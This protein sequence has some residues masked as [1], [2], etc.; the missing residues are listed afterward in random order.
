MAIPLLNTIPEILKHIQKHEETLQYNLRL[1]RAYEG[2]IRKEIEDSMREEIMSPAALRRALKRVPSINILK[3][4][5]DKL[6]K[7]YAEPVVRLTKNARDQ[8]LLDYYSKMANLDAVFMT[9]N[10]M[11]NL[12][13]M[14]AIEPFVEDGLPQFRVLAG[15]QFLPFSNDPVNPMKMNVFIK[16][17]GK[18]SK[19]KD[20]VRQYIKTDGILNTDDDEIRQVHLFQLFTD[21]EII[22]IDSDGAVRLDIM[23]EMGLDGS[24]PIGRIPHVYLN[25]S[26]HELV[27]FPDTTDMDVSVTVPK[28]ISDLNYAVQFMSH[29]MIWTKNVELGNQ[30]AHPDTILDLGD[31]APDGGDPEIGTIDPKVDIQGTL[32]LIEFQL[33]MYFSSK[34]IKSASMKNMLPG[35]EASGIAKAM[36]EGDTSAELKVQTEYFRMIE[37][38][39]WKMAKT[40][41]KYWSNIGIVNDRR[42]FTDKFVEDFALIFKE[43]KVIE[44]SQEKTLRIQSQKELGI[45]DRASMVKEFNP[46]FSDEQIKERLAQ[47]DKEKE[48]AMNEMMS[49]GMAFG[50]SAE[51]DNSDSDEIQFPTENS[52]SDGNN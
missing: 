52:N 8:Q 15:H 33:A 35:R 48:K 40:M 23:D 13:K 22:V 7:V 30:E 34:G 42:Q 51:N 43:L 31:S 28:L 19:S 4:A 27:P 11:L 21:K 46:D 41:Q 3:K 14:A 12:T 6:S 29:S 2:Q 37:R 1:Y 44:S 20:D 38:E 10:K 26:Q 47:V 16:L 45:I 17:L 49:R 50:D 24:N 32:S 18:K 39:F 5:T 9:A 36:D 25:K